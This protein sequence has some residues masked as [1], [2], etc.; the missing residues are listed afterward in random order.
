MNKNM[1]EKQISEVAKVLEAWNPLGELAAKFEDLSGYRYE[2]I[3]IIS[4][5]EIMQ[6]NDKFKRAIRQV[7]EQAF[8]ITVPDRGLDEASIK[9]EKIIK[10]ITNG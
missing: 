1:N 2:A 7:L 10:N 9:I 8:E 5:S 6:G 3:D 4:T